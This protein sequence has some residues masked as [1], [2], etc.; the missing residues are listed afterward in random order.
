M[1]HDDINDTSGMT[2]EQR[3]AH[4]QAQNDARTLADAEVIKNDADRLKAA[5][6]MAKRMADEKVEE[7]RAMSKV[8]TQAST[9][10][11]NNSN[12]EK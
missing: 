2:D 10:F 8:A 3:E 5:T 12:K 11:D 7:A 4:W 6:E 1:L 9:L